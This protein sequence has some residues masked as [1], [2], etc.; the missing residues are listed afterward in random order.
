MLM[1][2][3]G[4]FAEDSGTALFNKNCAQCHGTDG[5][6]KT[7]AAEKMPMAN[8]RSKEVQSMSDEEIFDTI[9]YGNKH[10]EYPHAFLQHGLTANDVHA[11]VVYI[12]TFKGKS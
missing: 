2:V 10:K 7:P 6:G 11:I 9:A 5:R 12:R 4:A 8:L 3:A 1:L